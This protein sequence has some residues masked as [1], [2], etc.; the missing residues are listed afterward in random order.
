MLAHFYA[1]VMTILFFNLWF[2]VFYHFESFDVFYVK[3]MFDIFK[4]SE[5]CVADVNL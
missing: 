4:P 5:N 3:N 1:I 2:F